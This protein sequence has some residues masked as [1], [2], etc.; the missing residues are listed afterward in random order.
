MSLVRRLAR[1]MLASSFIVSGVERLRDPDSTKHLSKAI[2]LASKAAPQLRALEG[3]E[4]LVGQALAGSQVAAGAL[5]ALGKLPRFSSTVLLAT[6]AINAYV[7]H[8]ASEAQTT[9][10]KSARR[11]STVRNASLL[12]AVAIASVDTDGNPSLAW[13][14]NKLGQQVAKKSSQLAG[15]VKDA[16]ND[17]HKKVENLFAS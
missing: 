5:F 15:D 2:G 10:Q 17:A 7:E 6:G 13:R 12:G 3:Q 4:K 9:E 11:Q 16:S 8:Q 14:A 1:P